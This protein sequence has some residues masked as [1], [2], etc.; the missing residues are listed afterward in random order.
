MYVSTA[1][2]IVQNTVNPVRKGKTHISR[3][4]HSTK[5]LQRLSRSHL[6]D[7][8]TSPTHV[9]PIHFPRQVSNPPPHPIPL[10][11]N[12]TNPPPTQRRRQGKFQNTQPTHDPRP[13]AT[14][15]SPRSQA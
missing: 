2:Y 3:Q 13:K 11:T 12:L 7:K 10:R 5:R 15:A 8:H 14:H 9:P 4:V 1:D 6:S